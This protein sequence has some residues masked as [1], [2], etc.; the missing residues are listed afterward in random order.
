MPAGGRGYIR[1]ASL[2]SVWS[3]APFLQNNTV[4][5]FNP[6]PSVSARMGSFQDSI[7]KL[8]WPEKRDKDSLLGDKIPGLMD[9]TTQTSYLRVSGG[10]LPDYLKP[11][12][13]PAQRFFPAIF[14]EGGIQLGPIPKG[15]P[16][17]LLSNFDLLGEPANSDE[18][19][20]RQEKVLKLLLKVKGDLDALPK[21]ATDED[22]RKVFANLVQPMLELN[23][24][25]DFIVNRGHYF[26]TSYFA[27]EPGLSDQDKRALI[28]F[29][30]TF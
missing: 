21:N 30:K 22:A 16:V 13:G 10:Y 12:I 23:K 19:R 3:T 8:L 15:T 27:E 25:P 18:K 28:E 4:G 1:P 11:L 7:E 29:L 9:R 17:E 26:G 20:Q 2:I 5:N 6:S 14:G 24:C